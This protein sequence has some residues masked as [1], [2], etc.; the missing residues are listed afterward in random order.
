MSTKSKKNQQK[1]AGKPRPGQGT[2]SGV[3]RKSG[4]RAKVKR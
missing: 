3:S 4:A 1:Y 2:G